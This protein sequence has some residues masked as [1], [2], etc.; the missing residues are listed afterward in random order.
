MVPELLP[1]GVEGW[2]PLAGVL[3]EVEGWELLAGV[4]VVE[5]AVA[6]ALALLPFGPGW[7]EA[8]AKAAAA[9]F[10]SALAAAILSCWVL[11]IK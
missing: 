5:T 7:P 8:A 10:A 6:E 3:V 1:D 11:F 4:L 2:E 9:V